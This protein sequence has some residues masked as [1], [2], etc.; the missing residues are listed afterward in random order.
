[1]NKGVSFSWFASESTLGYIMLTIA[2]FA[3]IVLFVFY[4]VGQYRLGYPLY[5]ECCV[6]AGAV[7]NFIDRIQYG[8][9]IDFIDF[10][11]GS[12]HF[13]TFNIA[14]I[15]ICTGITW[16]VLVQVKE[17]YDAQSKKNS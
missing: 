1:M 14:D 6:L 17:V 12:W 10:H 9:V 2:V 13:P 11:I 16:L 5:G 4:A 8:G 15:Y 3:I 7:S